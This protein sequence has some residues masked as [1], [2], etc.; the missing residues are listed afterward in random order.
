MKQI[1]YLQWIFPKI[2]QLQKH[3]LHFHSTYIV[4][5]TGFNI[6]IIAHSNEQKIV[7]KESDH[8]MLTESLICA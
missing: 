1:I 2:A 4:K 7:G 5:W 8:F 3:N 6:Y